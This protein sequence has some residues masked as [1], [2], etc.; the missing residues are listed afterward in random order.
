MILFTMNSFHISKPHLFILSVLG[1]AIASFG[2]FSVGCKPIFKDSGP[3]SIKIT[4]TTF[5]LAW[6]AEE[7]PLPN[8][9]SATDYFKVYYREVNEK[10]WKLLR[11]TE[12][13]SPQAM[14]FVDELKGSENMSSASRV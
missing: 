9:P 4:S 10:K 14:V 12:D 7:P 1:I 5:T 8:T 3:V 6:D 11:T 2:F 13:Y